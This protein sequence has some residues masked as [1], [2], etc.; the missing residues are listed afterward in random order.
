[1][2]EKDT[3]KLLGGK[4]GHIGVVTSGMIKVGDEAT[5]TVD[6]EHRADTCKRSAY[7]SR[8]KQYRRI[9]ENSK[10]SVK[11]GCRQKLSCNM[12]NST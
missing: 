2:A 1:M 8:S 6:A 12:Q 11:K 9:C 10:A 7:D 5:L 3:V 4:V